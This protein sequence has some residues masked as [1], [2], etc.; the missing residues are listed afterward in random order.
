MAKAALEH[1]T[2]SAAH[3][4]CP[5]DIAVNTFR[6]DVPVA[7]E[8][9]LFNMPD[10]DHSDWEP[11]EVAAEGIV[12]MLE[13]PSSYTG[14]NEGMARLRADYGIMASKTARPYRPQGALVTE[15]HLRPV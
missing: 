3:Q 4:L 11:S 6:I 13:Q 5:F 9:F 15:S 2:V 10:A 1:L 12:W 8:G 14:H 7:S